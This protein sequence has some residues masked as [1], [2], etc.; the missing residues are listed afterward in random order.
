MVT[1]LNGVYNEST[2]LVVHVSVTVGPS[3]S[4]DAFGTLSL[5]LIEDTSV[6]VEVRDR[7]V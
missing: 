7:P 2:D 1:C 6:V 5:N 4:M 3:R